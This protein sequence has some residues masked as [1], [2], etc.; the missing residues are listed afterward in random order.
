MKLV[1]EYFFAPSR[2]QHVWLSRESQV[3]AC[4]G[5]VLEDMSF[6]SLRGRPTS[7]Y[8]NSD[9]ACEKLDVELVR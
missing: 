1:E 5:Y 8:G 7:G 2:L 9:T 6:K 3:N 4:K